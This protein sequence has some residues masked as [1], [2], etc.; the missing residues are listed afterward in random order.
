M[1]EFPFFKKIRNKLSKAAKHLDEGTLVKSTVV[2]RTGLCISFERRE[3][4]DRTYGTIIISKSDY[5]ERITLN[6][7]DMA[8]TLKAMKAAW[9]P[10]SP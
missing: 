2:Q 3:K 6:E 1:R 10:N 5:V 9:D 8:A 4:D 7:S